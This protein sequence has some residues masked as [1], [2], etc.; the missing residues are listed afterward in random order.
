[1]GVSNGKIISNSII[2]TAS[3]ILIKCFSFFLLPLYTAYLTTAD[4]GVTNIANSFVSVMSFVAAFS[5]YSAVM[6]FYVDL[7][8]DEKKLRR[9]YG[10][11]ISFVAISCVFICVILYL[12]KDFVEK[13]IFSGIPFFPVVF[14]VCISL[15]FQCEHTIYD[16]IL[17][18]QQKAFKSSVLSIAYFLVTVALNI[19][20]VVVLK[21]GAVGSLLAGG[22]A[23]AVYTFYAIADMLKAKKITF[24]IDI[25]LL[26]S[27]LKYSIPI[28]P[29]N[30][31]THI[32][33]FVSSVLIGSTANFGALGVYSVALQFG[34]IADTVQNYV[35]HAYGPWLFEKLHSKEQGYKSSIRQVVNMLVSVIG[36]L[37]VGI[38]LFAHDYIVLLVDKD[39]AG[40][41]K[42]V[43][44][45][46]LVFAIK[47]MYY[48][49]VNI[50]FYFKKAS[51]ILFTATLSSSIINVLLSAIFIPL[52][53]AFGS[54]I[55]DA[56]AM[57]I[58]VIIIVF[59][60]KR[61]EDIG[62]RIKDFILNFLI[63]CAFVFT[64][65]IFSYTKHG[66]TFNILD[67]IYRIFI[68]CVYIA[69]LFIVYRKQ[70]FSFLNSIKSKR[71]I[72]NDKKN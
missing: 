72:K 28:L 69:Y 27:A 43:P 39:F 71:G 55:A 15:L 40:A 33:T 12:F 9:F 67:F 2:Y 8:D 20:F 41:W 44:F 1:M 51:K 62:L 22:I 24:C 61:F 26:K 52:Y 50:L 30:L 16:N 31:S 57:I 45:I 46:V 17:R 10:T 48:F 63:V 32:A 35:N 25:K 59:I 70:I 68:V 56:V 47:T 60:S 5:L 66:N 42:Y 36:L 3:G 37:F 49:Y 34:H 18:S 4:Y 11:I 38:A 54:I 19:V 64:G 21:M 23:S 13:Y 6:R 7:K 29:H 58:R 65:L 53:G 14:I